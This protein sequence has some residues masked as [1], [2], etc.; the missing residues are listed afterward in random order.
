MRQSSTL[1]DWDHHLNLD[2]DPNNQ[3][4]FFNE[5]LLN[6]SKNFIPNEE[7]IFYPKDPPWLTKTCKNL[8]QKYKRQYKSFSKRGFPQSDKLRIDELKTEYATL[9]Q[10]EKVRYTQSLGSA[11]SDPKTG[12]KKYWTFLKRLINNKVSTIIPPML[13]NGL[14]VTDV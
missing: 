4:K 13:H 3:A 6:I 2:Q 8:Y 9:V 11:I 14:F 7:K 1:F 12:S 5:T 10:T